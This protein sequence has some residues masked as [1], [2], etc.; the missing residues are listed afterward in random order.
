MLDKM[1]VIV[2]KKINELEKNYSKRQTAIRFNFRQFVSIN[3]HIKRSDV[4]THNIHIQADY[5]PIFLFSF[6]Q[7]INFVHLKVKS[8]IHSQGVEQ[9]FWNLSLIHILKEISME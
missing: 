7:V 8:S 6:F 3:L 9:Y 1:S 4:Y 2:Y 5:S